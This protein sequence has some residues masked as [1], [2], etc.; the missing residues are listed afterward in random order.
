MTRSE[1]LKDFT[2]TLKHLNA[3]GD[4][5]AAHRKA[6]K[7]LIATLYLLSK[8]DPELAKPTKELIKAYGLVEKWYK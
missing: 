8:H 1:S 7:I 4:P 3:L 2:S 6:D 5:E